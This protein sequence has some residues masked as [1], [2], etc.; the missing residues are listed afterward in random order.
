MT[1]FNP[2]SFTPFARHEAAQ[3]QPADVAQAM[4]C[5]VEL[6]EAATRW[7]A[8]RDDFANGKA[9]TCHDIATKLEQFGSFASDRQRQ[10]AVQLIEWSKP[11]KALPATYERIEQLHKAAPARDPET[12]LPRLFDLMQRLSKLTIGKLTVTR[13]N[14]AS[15]CWVKHEAAE[16][17]VGKIEGG[18]LSIY[19][20][21][22]IDMQAVLDALLLIEADPEAAAALHGKLSGRCSVCSRDLTDPESIERGIGPTCA[23]KF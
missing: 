23:G 22:G 2:A 9:A 16:R 8:R 10:Y 13:K 1:S 4:H 19:G 18:V 6:R 15:L 17:V 20:R 7:A 21:P 12:R 3:A 5:A 11:R 14:Q